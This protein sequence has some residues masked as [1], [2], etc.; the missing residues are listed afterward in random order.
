MTCKHNRFSGRN[1]SHR[2]ECLWVNVCGCVTM[3]LVC[4]HVFAC[5][6]LRCFRLSRLPRP[7]L[8]A[9]GGAG[10]QYSAMGPRRAAAPG[11]SR[12]PAA[13]DTGTGGSA[14]G[15]KVED[16]KSATADKGKGK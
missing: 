6:I 13:G 12:P 15:D 10:A 7:V 16:V 3:T 2:Y 9:S 1:A 14:T 11:D 8:Q 4:A 5:W